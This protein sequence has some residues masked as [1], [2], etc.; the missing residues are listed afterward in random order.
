MVQS[1]RT[2]FLQPTLPSQRDL[3]RDRRRPVQ[4]HIRSDVAQES[5]RGPGPG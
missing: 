5:N 2:L 3:R 1:P 4:I